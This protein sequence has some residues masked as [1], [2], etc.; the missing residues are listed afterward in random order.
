MNATLPK[1]VAHM[2]GVRQVGKVYAATC[3]RCSF[4]VNFMCFPVTPATHSRLIR[5]VDHHDSFDDY[6]DRR[7][8]PPGEVEVDD[9]KK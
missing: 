1:S 3:V 6:V 8:V 9:E 2:F 7:G 5:H 4:R